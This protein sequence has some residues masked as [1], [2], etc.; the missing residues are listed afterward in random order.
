MSQP[1]GKSWTGHIDV[2]VQCEELWCHSNGHHILSL[3]KK[4]KSL[5]KELIYAHE[6]QENDEVE[7]GD[8]KFKL[9]K[10]LVNEK[11]VLVLCVY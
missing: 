3:W 4:G 11:I 8:G 1:S 9:N 2:S 5:L 6:A 7:E 10:Y